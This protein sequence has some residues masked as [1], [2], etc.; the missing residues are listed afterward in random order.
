ML[1]E[2]L[3]NRESL[4]S[5]FA[6]PHCKANHPVSCSSDDVP[7]RLSLCSSLV[8]LSSCQHVCFVPFALDALP[9]SVERK[10]CSDMALRMLASMRSVGTFFL[11]HH[12]VGRLTAIK[13]KPAS[14]IHMKVCEVF[15][16]DL[17]ST[18][19]FCVFTTMMSPAMT[20]PSDT[21]AVRKTQS[22]ANRLLKDAW[23]REIGIIGI[24]ITDV[25]MMTSATAKAKMIPFS[26]P[27][28][29]LR[30]AGDADQTLRSGPHCNGGRIINA[31][32][33]RLMMTIL[34]YMMTRRV[35]VRPETQKI[36]R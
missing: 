34:A 28:R 24:A 14:R 13:A 16:L 27:Q 35:S 17:S 22:T 33:H 10:D 6:K 23:R 26:M 32:V 20:A 4:F 1:A 7:S 8:S 21:K 9:L 36:R 30:T 25:S 31:A 2:S 18:L 19:F 11:S 3:R 12:K 29:A 5:A 15:A